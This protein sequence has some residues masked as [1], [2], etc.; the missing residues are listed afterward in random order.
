MLY[1]HLSLQEGNTTKFLLFLR[2]GHWNLIAI[3]SVVGITSMEGNVKISEYWSV[4]LLVLSVLV[5]GI[6]AVL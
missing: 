5:H 3:I 6:C 4:F 2:Y 1:F